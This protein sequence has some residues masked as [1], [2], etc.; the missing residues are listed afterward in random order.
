MGGGNA[1]KT[2]MARLRNQEKLAK[3]KK[4]G[5]SQL[6]QNAK[7]HSYICSICRTAF[8]CTTSE[9]MLRDHVAAKH[10][11]ATFE[12]CFPNFEAPK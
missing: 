3:A 4:G 2:A 8:L 12:A 6:K 11:K 1:Q 5:T 10:D 9:K 7:A